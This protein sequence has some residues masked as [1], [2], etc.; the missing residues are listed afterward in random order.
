MRFALMDVGHGF[1]M[2]KF[3]EELDRNKVMEEGPWMI[4]AL[5]AS[6]GKPIKVDSN[7]VDVRLGRFSQETSAKPG[8]AVS[9]QPSQ[10]DGGG[11]S[12]Q[13]VP[14]TTMKEG[15]S[16]EGAT[17]GDKEINSSNNNVT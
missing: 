9:N 7:I 5:I 2:A 15:A 17:Q 8:V 3:D 13:P 14:A 6:I 11:V 12:K 1:Y 10:S 4:F 16:G